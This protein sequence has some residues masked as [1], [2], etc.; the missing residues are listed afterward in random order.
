MYKVT[1]KSADVSPFLFNLSQIFL[2]IL[3]Y[4]IRVLTIDSSIVITEIFYS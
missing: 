4:L 3:F 1:K 2:T